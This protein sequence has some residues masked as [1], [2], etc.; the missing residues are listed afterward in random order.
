VLAA[1]PCLAG[2]AELRWDSVS[3]P[4]L[5]GYR[6]FY[7]TQPGTF[8]QHIDVGLTTTHTVTGLTDCALY[9]FAVKAIDAGGLLSSEY[10]NLVSGYTRPTIGTITPAQV[11]PALLAEI[12][13][14]GTGFAP[15]AVAEILGLGLYS[16]TVN[17]CGR[18]TLQLEVPPEAA[19][20]SDLTILNTDGSFAARPGAV[21]V[22]PSPSP[23]AVTSVVPAPGASG[24][25]ADPLIEVHF[26]APVDPRSVT[27]SKLK[28][29]KVGG[30]GTAKIEHGYPIFDPARKKLTLRISGTLTADQSYAIFVKGGRN[31][32]LSDSSLTLDGDYVQSPA[33]RTS[34]LLDR[35]YYGPALDGGSATALAPL[36]PDEPIPTDSVL[37]VGFNET[38]SAGYVSPFSFKI[39]DAGKHIPLKAG[40]PKLS[41]DGRSVVLE[42]A[43]PLPAGRDL[44]IQVKGGRRGARSERGV[45][46]SQSVRQIEFSTEAETIQGLGVAE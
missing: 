5:V 40:S 4:D 9:H 17:S 3:S 11:S 8:G 42:P 37:V 6:L 27:P 43:S 32:V 2:Q 24:V 35:P 41:A 38:M 10:S 36:L 46:M 39:L 26:S 31:G 16:T 19:G 18:M 30:N 23:F 1:T 25:D 33:F 14:E 15:G 45:I 28:I 7:D 22:V 13:V 20:A 44:V 21:T 29:L 34:D 12:V